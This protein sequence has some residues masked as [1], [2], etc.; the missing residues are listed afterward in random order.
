MIN[1][2]ITR[3][4]VGILIVVSL[5]ST[6]Y[7]SYQFSSAMNSFSE[8]VEEITAPYLIYKEQ[9]ESIE[10]LLIDDD[11]EVLNV[12]MANYTTNSP[13]FEWYEIKDDT[14]CEEGEESC[15][16]DKVLVSIEMKS[17]GSRSEQI[18]DALII[19]DVIFPN[20]FVHLITIK[21]PTDKCEYTIFGVKKYFE[22]YD[23]EVRELIQKQ[24]DE[25]GKC[26]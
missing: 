12:L 4:V 15:T 7:S 2:N 1:N 25:F 19:S 13:F 18:W 8:N 16:T 11:Y 14:I 9:E 22:T 21:S 10:E 24:I 20:T 23:S 5:I 26:S 6:S 17:F 3:W